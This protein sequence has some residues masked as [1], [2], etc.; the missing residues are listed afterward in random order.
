MKTRIAIVTALALAA[1]SGVAGA[2]WHSRA[3]DAEQ[4]RLYCPVDGG[5]CQHLEPRTRSLPQLAKD[6]AL[7]WELRAN[8]AL[9]KL[10]RQIHWQASYGA[11]F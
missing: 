6:Q 8:R 4:A 10:E 2:T 1:G 5:P 11:R 9:A 3:N 7:E